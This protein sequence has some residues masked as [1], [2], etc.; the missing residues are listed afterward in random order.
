MIQLNCLI[1]YF[2]KRNPYR[3]Q[4][5]AEFRK[6]PSFVPIDLDSLQLYTCLLLL[7]IQ[8]MYTLTFKSYYLKYYLATCY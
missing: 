3:C 4:S 2:V 1:T 7:Y 8:M 6:F 5:Y